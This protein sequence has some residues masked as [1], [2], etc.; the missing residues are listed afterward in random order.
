MKRNKAFFLMWMI[1]LFP[2]GMGIIEDIFIIPSPA[3]FI[4]SLEIPYVHT[5]TVYN[6][7]LFSIYDSRDEN[8]SHEPKL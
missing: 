7:V 4:K 2:S 3:C 1:R 5:H 6:T 8:I